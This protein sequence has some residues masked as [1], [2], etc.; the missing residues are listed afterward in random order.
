MLSWPLDHSGT[1]GTLRQIYWHCP[2]YGFVFSAQYRYFPFVS[3]GVWQYNHFPIYSFCNVMRYITLGPH[4]AE[5]WL[6]NTANVPRKPRFHYTPDAYLGLRNWNPRG[7]SI[8]FSQRIGTC[9]GEARSSMRVL[10]E[11]GSRRYRSPAS[12]SARVGAFLSEP[13]FQPSCGSSGNEVV[14]EITG[15]SATGN[16]FSCQ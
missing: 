6:N 13:L 16:S 8:P 4:R 10:L 9:P 3:A 14:R 11:Q 7:H 15:A 1:N 2:K 5:L 12:C